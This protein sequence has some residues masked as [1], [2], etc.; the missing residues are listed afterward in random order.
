MGGGTIDFGGGG[1]DGDLF[2]MKLDASGNHLWSKGYEGFGSGVSAIAADSAGNVVVAGSY[3]S[4]IEFGGGPLADGNGGAAF[5]VK[6]D[7]HGNHLWSKGLTYSGVPFASSGNCM[8]LDA[9]DN[10]LVAGGF[11]GT[12]DL[13]GGPIVSAHL[14]NSG[15]V[16][17]FLLKLDPEGNH[18]WS[19]G[20][21]CDSYCA[22]S[23]VAVDELGNAF[24]TGWFEG[25]IDLGGGPLTSAGGKDVFVAKLAP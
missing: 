20:Y 11:S 18:L 5:V 1:I 13:G 10:V 4:T 15:K 12:V 8:A 24:L 25:T 17:A 9:S 23:G 3:Y 21:G 6:L 16:D 19:R 14:P 22:A 7:Q 2:V